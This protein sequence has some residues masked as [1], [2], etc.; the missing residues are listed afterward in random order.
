MLAALRCAMM[1][2]VVLFGPMLCYATYAVL[3]CIVLCYAYSRIRCSVLCYAILCY[4]ALCYTMLHY[5]VLCYAMPCFDTLRCAI[6]CQ[7]VLCCHSKMPFN[8]E[9]CG[10]DGVLE[11]ADM[12]H[13]IR[14]AHVSAVRPAG[15]SLRP[16]GPQPS[17][18]LR[19]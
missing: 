4:A 12:F 5:A 13:T 17:A 18:A 11:T 6:L 7:A 16:A 9:C 14:A 2:C 19:W 8:T 15:G 10:A 3:C 1:C